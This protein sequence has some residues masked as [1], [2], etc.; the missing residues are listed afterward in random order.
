MRARHFSHNTFCKRWPN[1]SHFLSINKV[2][3]V[4]SNLLHGFKFKKQQLPW[5]D[6]TCYEWK[7]D[8]KP[9]Q[10]VWHFGWNRIEGLHNKNK[11]I[12]VCVYISL[13]KARV[14]NNCCCMCVVYI[15][16]YW[17]H[18]RNL[19]WLDFCMDS[20]ENQIMHNLK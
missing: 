3:L 17:Y 11:S 16:I 12:C 9:I 7:R 5:F 2:Q 1:D 15:N 4:T 10:S 19:M 6:S 8:E 13:R 14:I 20:I 18:K